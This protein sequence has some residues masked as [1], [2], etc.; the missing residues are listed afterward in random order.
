[1]ANLSRALLNL[2]EGLGHMAQTAGQR[3]I[4]AMR[5]MRDENFLRLQEGF[6]QQADDR[7]F[8]QQK[9]LLGIEDTMRGAAETRRQGFETSQLNTRL[10][11]ETQ[12]QNQEAGLTRERFQREDMTTLE[13]GYAS[14]INAIDDRLARISDQIT[15]AQIK[16]GES[17]LEVDPKLLEPWQQ[18]I[19]QL[20]SQKKILGRE[21]DVALSSMS[22]SG[23]EKLT[24]RQVEEA[25]AS[26]PAPGGV[27][28]MPRKPQGMID[29]E[30]RK[31]KGFIRESADRL[32]RVAGFGIDH[33]PAAA[34]F[35]G[36]VAEKL[37]L[38]DLA[39]DAFHGVDPAE[40][41]RRRAAAAKPFRGI[42]DTITGAFSGAKSDTAL[43][44]QAKQALRKVGGT[45]TVTPEQRAQLARMGATQL[46]RV[47][48]F[49]D[50][51]LAQIGL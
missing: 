2:G 42:A 46:K 26:H 38:G 33:A 50:R 12:L 17:M 25:R 29:R 3:E 6:R 22:G 23:Y 13:R 20:Q 16:A 28:E 47:Y 14:Q 19:A 51:E 10:A 43:A 48:G 41:A 34:K 8:G 21:R 4:E 1:M 11:H 7:Q 35:V 15:K 37:G 40:A 27:P 31:E 18:E 24:Q 44:H 39:R 45:R 49:T 32:A 9:E 5:A 30:Q 36:G